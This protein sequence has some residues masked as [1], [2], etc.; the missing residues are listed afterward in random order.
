MYPTLPINNASVRDLCECTDHLYTQLEYGDKIY[1]HNIFQTYT[2]NHETLILVDTSIRREIRLCLTLNFKRSVIIKDLTGNA[3]NNPILI[4]LIENT[5]GINQYYTI[6]NSAPTVTLPYGSLVPTPVTVTTIVSP[7]AENSVT[8]QGN[9]ERQFQMYVPWGSVEFSCYEGEWVITVPRSTCISTRGFRLPQNLNLALPPSQ[10]AIGQTFGPIAF[11]PANMVGQDIVPASWNGFS[12]SVHTVSQITLGTGVNNVGTSLPI[13]TLTSLFTIPDPPIVGPTTFAALA[14]VANTTFDIPSDFPSLLAAWNYLKGVTIMPGNTVT[15]TLTEDDSISSLFVI[16]HPQL[17]QIVIQGAPTYTFVPLDTNTFSQVPGQVLM[18]IYLESY[19]FALINVGDTILVD[20]I[21]AAAFAAIEGQNI[22]DFTRWNGAWQ[23]ISK[24]TILTDPN[25]NLGPNNTSSIRIVITD[26]SPNFPLLDLR[27]QEVR[28]RLMG[29]VVTVAGNGSLQLYSDGLTINNVA[30]VGQ[31]NALTGLTCYGITNLNTVATI[32][33]QANGVYSGTRGVL[34]AQDLFSCSNLNGVYMERG[35]ILNGDLNPNGSGIY[36]NGNSNAG[37]LQLN[38]SSEIKPL[39]ATGNQNF[40]VSLNKKSN[41][42]LYN[43]FIQ[44]NG[45]GLSIIG[46]STAT[47]NTNTISTNALND[48]FVYDLSLVQMTMTSNFNT[49][50]SIGV[51][52]PDGSLI[53]IS[54]TTI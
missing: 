7:L 25:I 30:F 51:V 35:S 12:A 8:L 36:L 23:V 48:I 14:I 49:S 18:D 13:G 41:A 9:T 15:L 16:D 40:G 33:F 21:G 17:S 10:G 34:N 45:T 19:D 38:S 2:Y 1:V 20:Q 54:G 53:D 28:F 52:T 50:S 26:W 11:F 43:C 47:G 42:D 27:Q 31:S 29:S 37:L 4:T 24:S 6:P 5:S 3:G 32:G 44:N 22:T 39:F 46:E